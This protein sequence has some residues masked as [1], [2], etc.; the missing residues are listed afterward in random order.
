MPELP[1]ITVYIEALKSRIQGRQLLAIHIVGPF[2]LRS[3][4]P[5]VDA[6]IDKR[7][8][9][10][11]RLG[12]RIVIGMEDDLWM[13]LHLMIAGRLLWHHSKVKV[14]R[15]LDLAV[16]DFDSGTLVLTEAGTK[17]RASLYVVRGEDAL[18]AHR[19]GVR[20]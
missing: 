17:K 1:D 5:S 3:V 4:D 19:P 12:K 10:I 15:K 11:R 8:V 7:V 16:L 14:R 9:D 6:L 2:L 18:S 20:E 13:V